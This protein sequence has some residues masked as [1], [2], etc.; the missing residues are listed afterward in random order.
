MFILGGNSEGFISSTCD[1]SGARSLHLFS[2]CARLAPGPVPKEDNAGFA[3][4]GGL[5]WPAGGFCLVLICFASRESREFGGLFG[6][7]V[8][9]IRRVDP[10]GS[11][12]FVCALEVADLGC[13]FCC[14]DW[15]GATFFDGGGVSAGTNKAEAVESADRRLGALRDTMPASGSWVSMISELSLIHI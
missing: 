13:A 15:R 1:K 9:E 8:C 14:S 7:A 3:A 2:R 5:F 10:G 12:R 6:V 4:C 11:F